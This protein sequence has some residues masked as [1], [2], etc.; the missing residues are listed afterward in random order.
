MLWYLDAHRLS[1]CAS[2]LAVL[3]N[4]APALSPSAARLAS[5]TPLAVRLAMTYVCMVCLRFFRSSYQFKIR[6]LITADI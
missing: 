3:A 1:L 5:R 4:T 2:R 6:T